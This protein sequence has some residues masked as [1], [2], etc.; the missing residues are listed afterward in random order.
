MTV[1]D[2]IESLVDNGTFTVREKR[3][4]DKPVGAHWVLRVKRNADGTIERYKGRVVAKGYSQ[5]P[6][7][8]NTE[9]FALTARWAA[10]RAI[11]ALAA[12]EDMEVE[13]VD[14]SSA[15]LNGDLQETITMEVFEGLRELK[16]EIFPKEGPKRDSDWVLELNK[17]L[18]GLKQSPR[19]WH[20]KLHSAMTEMEFERVQCNNSI[21]VYLNSDIRVYVPVYVDD[22]TIVSKNTSKIA[23]V[24]SEL[25]KRF[26]LRELGPTNSYLEFM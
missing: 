26:K 12:L 16:P 25:K 21:W 22:I 24:K 4:G 1:L 13:S 20:Q 10:L 17:A 11:F 23:W 2:E 19:M 3:N 7:F 8:D 5:R 18:Y 15:F 6:G 9:T 14:I